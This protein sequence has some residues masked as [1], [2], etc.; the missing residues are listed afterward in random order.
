MGRKKCPHVETMEKQMCAGKTSVCPSQGLEQEGETSIDLMS[1]IA[2]HCAVTSWSEWSPCSVTCGKGIKV[3]T[4]LYKV[5]PQQRETNAACNLTLMQKTDCDGLRIECA[6]TV[7]EAKYICGLEKEMGQ[8]RGFMP[9]WHFN[10]KTKMCLQFIYTGC[11]GNSNNFETYEDCMKV[12]ETPLRSYGAP[13]NYIGRRNIDR[14][15]SSRNRQKWMGSSSSRNKG[16]YSSFL[17]DSTSSSVNNQIQISLNRMPTNSTTIIPLQDE[18]TT[19]RLLKIQMKQRNISFVEEPTTDRNLDL[20]KRKTMLM[21]IDMNSRYAPSGIRNGGFG[22]GALPLMSGKSSR[23]NVF[24]TREER[25][26]R[27]FE[28]ERSKQMSQMKRRMMLQGS[29]TAEPLVDCLVT[30]WSPWSECSGTC[31]TRSRQPG[32]RQGIPTREKFRMIKRYD[33]GGGRKCP[34]RLRRRQKCNMPGCQE[35]CGLG[36]WGEW[37]E[38]SQ[39]CG[40]DGVQER[41]RNVQNE[42]EVGGRPCGPRKESRMCTLADCS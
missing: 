30:S 22:S 20:I 13:T 7:E 31:E 10:S 26:R 37:S 11:R 41:L 3:R 14:Y 40:Q 8:C 39:S 29:T 2:P 18:S 4:R 9:R 12:C 21:Q 15:S 38:C 24:E 36:E 19:E 16:G 27:L 1:N 17:P 32:S 25:R 34:K 33:S 35:E 6:F 42:P 5:S 28:V 23:P